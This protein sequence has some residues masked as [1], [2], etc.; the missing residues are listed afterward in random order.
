[1]TSPLSGFYGMAGLATFSPERF[2][3][4]LDRRGWK[5]VL[6]E[7]AV[8]CPCYSEN[9]GNPDPLDARCGGLGFTYEEDLVIQVPQE[10]LTVE[11]DGQFNFTLRASLNG[12]PNPSR[13]VA[14]VVVTNATTG[15]VYAA[16]RYDTTKIQ[17]SGG[18]LPLATDLVYAAYTYNRDPGATVRAILMNVDYQRDFIPAS[19]WLQGDV[20]MTVSGVYKLGFRDRITIPEEVVRTTEFERRYALDVNGRSLERLIYKSGL[21]VLSVYDK[22]QTFSSPA[23][24]TITAPYSLITWGFGNRP[25]HQIFSLQYTGNGTSAVMTVTGTALAV[26]VAGATDGSASMNLLFSDFPTP[27][28][29]LA[30]VAA[31]H[32]GYVAVAAEDSLV[33]GV[34]QAEDMTKTFPVAVQDVK[35]APYTLYNEDKTQYAVD[36]MHYLAYTVWN[37]QPQARRPDQGRVLPQK[38][39]LRLWEYTDR[40]SN[41]NAG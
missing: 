41:A 16:K 10:Q 37:K 12:T 25:K 21:Q 19:E 36:Y 34:D 30:E 31:H 28:A 18:V 35:A 15:V 3:D 27:A 39:W 2:E 6:W 29:L 40:F 23:D 33:S 8:K 4:F 22:Y 1:M 5:S 20:V 11:A 32:P 14:N 17:I 24:Y 13:V 38:Q 7:R 26:T 9:T